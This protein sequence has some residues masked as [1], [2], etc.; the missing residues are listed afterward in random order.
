MSDV[1]ANLQVACPQCGAGYAVPLAKIGPQ[2]RKLKCAA[3]GHVWVVNKELGSEERGTSAQE[4]I[5]VEI[6][7]AP[8]AVPAEPSAPLSE[9]SEVSEENFAPL[10][11]LEALTQTPPWWQPYVVG[12]QKWFSLALGLACLGMLGAAVVLWQRLHPVPAP[13]GVPLYV[14]E[15]FAPPQA[16][17]APGGVVLDN[18]QATA[19]TLPSG[20]VLT[21]TG[22]VANTSPQAQPLPTLRAELL[23]D[24]NTVLDFQAV[25]LVTTTLPA[26]M[27]MNFVVSFTNPVGVVW[28]L[29]WV[30]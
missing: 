17:A 14:G 24:A 1:G 15:S 2:G 11:R 4:P 30:R 16:V 21:I 3:C 26:Q 5:T 8:E 28:R 23:D 10:V 9:V 18:V 12:E 27:G 25:A 19:E 22:L 6:P 13:N 29:N 7:P 20:A